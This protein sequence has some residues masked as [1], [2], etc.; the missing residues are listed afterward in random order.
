[1][2]TAAGVV[3]TILNQDKYFTSFLWHPQKA[4]KGSCVYRENASDTWDILYH[5]ST[6][7]P[8]FHNSANER[9]KYATL[10]HCRTGQKYGLKAELNQ[11]FLFGGIINPLFNGLTYN[12][13]GHFGDSY[14]E[15]TFNNIHKTSEIDTS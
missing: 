6:I 11:T 4:R 8:F 14:R 10:L 13:S 9:A 2:K 3:A 5:Y 1:M 7:A 15:H 12:T